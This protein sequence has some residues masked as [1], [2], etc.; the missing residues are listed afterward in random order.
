MYQSFRSLTMRAV[1]VLAMASLVG[2]PGL[3]AQG[4]TPAATAGCASAQT[5]EAATNDVNYWVLDFD[6]TS[7]EFAFWG[8]I[9]MPANYDG[10][11]M[12]AIFYWT[13]IAA[14]TDGVAW[15]IQLLSLDDNDLVDSAWG[16]AVVVTDDAQNS[17]AAKVL[18]TDATADITPGGT[19]SAPELLFVRVFRD[20]SD[21]NDDMTEDA[22]L[23]GVKL[24]YGVNAVSD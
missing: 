20:V 11:V 22:R 23:I 16:T 21:A 24:L 2:A 14:D 7:D 1:G 10:G 5:I 3:L 17:A 6:A 4:G 13:T 18:I 8:P 12:T 9:A 15:A 19:A